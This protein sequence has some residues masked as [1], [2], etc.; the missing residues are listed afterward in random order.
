MKALVEMLPN[1]SGLAGFKAGDKGI[2]EGFLNGMP[3]V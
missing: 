3:I 1:S 2:I